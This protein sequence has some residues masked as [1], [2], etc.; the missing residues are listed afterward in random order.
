ML[1]NPSSFE[2]DSVSFLA[3]AESSRERI[4]KVLGYYITEGT[5]DT[6]S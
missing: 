4:C 2:E 1:Q 3:V 6:K 5:N